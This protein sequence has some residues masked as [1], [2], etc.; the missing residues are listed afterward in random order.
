MTNDDWNR[1]I[2][3]EVQEPFCVSANKRKIENGESESNRA[4][5][6]AVEL[7][8]GEFVGPAVRSEEL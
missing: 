7:R 3:S 6:N 8:T 4:S 2:G 5:R 1:V